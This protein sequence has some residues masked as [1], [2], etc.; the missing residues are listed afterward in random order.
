MCEA[1]CM[2]AC[3]CAC[4]R[5]VG[6]GGGRGSCLCEARC[7]VCGVVRRGYSLCKPERHVS[8]LCVGKHG[9]VL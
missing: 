7:V 1:R 3:V 5:A 4:V 2:Y 8:G 6:W 9:T